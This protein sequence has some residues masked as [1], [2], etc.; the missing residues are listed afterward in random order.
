[1]NCEIVRDLLPLYHDGV[2]SQESRAAVEEHLASCGACRRLLAD[3]DAPLP[4]T[5][6]KKND[7]GAAAVE[8]IAREWRR[9]RWKSWLRGAAA[10]LLVC[11]LLVGLWLAATELFVFTVPT[12]KIVLSNVRRLSDGRVLY[13]FYVDDDKALRVLTWEFDEAGNVYYL[14]RRALI[15]E[16]RMLPSM[17]DEDRELDIPEVNAWARANGV[18]TEIVRA[19]Y[20]R[21]EDAILLWEEGME[22]PAASELD[23]ERYGFDTESAAY[24]ARHGG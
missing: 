7:G 12:E 14:P 21:G 22:L 2:C 19:W 8:K 13:H 15:T 20:G 11:G 1:M 3:M 9:G 17:A 24:L 18:D 23:E 6:A 5:G 16:R 10:A 4:E